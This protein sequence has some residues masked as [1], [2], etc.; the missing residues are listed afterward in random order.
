ME[1]WMETPQDNKGWQKQALSVIGAITDLPVEPDAA[2]KG[3]TVLREMILAPD[4][5]QESI[6]D[7]Q[8]WIEW[9]KAKFRE[10]QEVRQLA[11]KT[12]L[13][14]EWRIGNQLAE[15]PAAPG[16]EHYHNQGGT[17]GLGPEV[18]DRPLTI[19]ELVGR[20]PKYGWRLKQM[21]ALSLEGLD[22]SV[23][24]LHRNGMEAT[25]TGVVQLL[26]MNERSERAAWRRLDSMTAPR[27][28]SGM[29]LRI[30]DCRQVL[31]DIAG[32]SIALVLTDPP[33]GNDAE[34]LYDYLGA[35][36]ARVLVPG[37]SLICYTGTATLPRDI[38]I[39][40]RHLKYHWT[41]GMIHGPGQRLFGAGVIA[42]WKPILWFVKERRRSA[43]L[44][45][46]VVRSQV[47]KSKHAWAQGDGGVAHWIHLLTDPEEVILDPF[48]GTAEWGRI[49]V[50]MGRR[51]IGSDVVSGGDETVV[52]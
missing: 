2:I 19:R 7:R 8:A 5:T 23:D 45:A 48:A 3:L 41:G 10:H 40:S 12:F 29:D 43:Q 27:I 52:A 46:D 24:E 33:Y 32:N 18:L 11:E 20:D 21:R 17:S 39:L 9:V 1:E 51:W 31:S 13:V 47:D 30:G 22:S 16:G 50:E 6:R 38:E 28:Q 25:L 26:R 4:A 14:G 36:A 44:V 34:V 15:Q 37:G 42:M 49:A 35:L